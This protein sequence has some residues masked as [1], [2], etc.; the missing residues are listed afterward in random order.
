MT[1]LQPGTLENHKRRFPPESTRVVQK[2][3]FVSNPLKCLCFKHFLKKSSL[4]HPNAYCQS[5]SNGNQHVST[6]CTGFLKTKFWPIGLLQEVILT[7]LFTANIRQELEYTEPFTVNIRQELVYT[8]LFT[9]DN[10]QELGYT[11]FWAVAY[12]HSAA[13]HPVTKL[14]ILIGIK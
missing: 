2:Y 5:I 13:P 4:N 14:L 12:I 11:D 3:I 8:E 9:V 7:E 1:F 6:C 10:R